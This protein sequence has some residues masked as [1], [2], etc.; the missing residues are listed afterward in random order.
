ML[1]V[2]ILVRLRTFSLSSC[3]QPPLSLPSL[4]PFL[5]LS[6]HHVSPSS[7]YS[8]FSSTTRTTTAT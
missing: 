1:S 6:L 5:L 4:P 7:R 3:S 2:T 8:A